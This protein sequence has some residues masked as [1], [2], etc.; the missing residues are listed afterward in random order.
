MQRSRR[1]LW[2]WTVTTVA[3]GLV[4]AALVVGVFRLAVLAAPSY[5]QDIEDWV[6]GVMNRPVDIGGMDLTWR[7]LRPTLKFSDVAL[8]GVS[9]MTPALEVAELEL[10]FTLS[11]LVRGRIMPVA[12]NVVGAVVE[13][14]R[15]IEGTVRIRGVNVSGEG[16]S[17]LVS[18][19]LAGLA[20]VRMSDASLLWHD[21]FRDRPPLWFRDVDMDIDR[22][23][24]DL[25]I[26]LSGTSHL[27][28]GRAQATMRLSRS[29][30]GT[31]LGVGGRARIEALE[32]GPWMDA[33]LPTPIGLIGD[34]LEL[35][36]QFSWARGESVVLDGQVRADRLRQVSGPGAMDH[37]R[38]EF[39]ATLDAAQQ[40]LVVRDLQMGRDG[41][42]WTADRVVV[43]RQASEARRWLAVQATHLQMESLLPWLAGVDPSGLMHRVTGD[44]SDLLA[45][46]E[47]SD[48]TADGPPELSLTARLKGA[49][50]IAEGEQPAV[51][52]LS[53]VLSLTQDRGALELDSEDVTIELPATLAHPVELDQLASSVQWQREGER[54]R[55]RLTGLS[56]AGHAARANGSVELVL[57]GEAPELDVE[58][59]LSSEDAT[60]LKSLIPRQWHPNLRAWLEQ[61]VVQGRV[62]S[63]RLRLVGAVD[64]FPFRD[65][66][67]TFRLELNINPGTLSIGKGWPTIDDAVA[68]LVI[69][70]ESL[71][72]DAVSG[73]ILGV[74]LTPAT[75]TL[76]DFRDAV[77]VAEGGANGSLDRM[78]SFLSNSPL[79][80]QVGYLD[81]VLEPRGFGHLDLA[82]EIPLKDIQA[83]RF[84][85]TVT[86]TGIELQSSQMPDVFR[87]VQGTIGFGNDGLTSTG[88]KGVFREAP[89]RVELSTV[90]HPEG[91]STQLSLQTPVRFDTTDDPW[92]RL[93]PEALRRRLDGHAS[94]HAELI[95]G[96]ELPQSLT[97]TSDLVNAVSA[98][99]APLNKPDPES[100]LPMRL[101]LPI[102]AE[103]P[104]IT[105]VELADRL[106]AQV[107]SEE[108]RWLAAAGLGFGGG[109]QPGIPDTGV[110]VT[111]T[112]PEVDVTEWAAWLGGL[113]S[114]QEGA[115]ASVTVDLTAGRLAAGP[116]RLGQQSIRGQLDGQGAEFSLA[117]AAEGTLRWE[118]AGR[119]RWEARLDHL[120]T[121][122]LAK[123]DGPDSDGEPME[124]PQRWPAIDVEIAH[125]QVA[126]LDAGRLTFKAEPRPSGI[127]LETLRLEGGELDLEMGGYAARPDD[128]TRAGLNGVLETPRI[129]KVMFAAGFVPNVRAESARIVLNLG[130]PDSPEGLHLETATGALD[131]SFRDGALAAVDPG[132]GRVLGLFSFYAL[133]RRLLLDFRDMT[134][135]GLTFDGIDGHFRISGGRAQ[136][137][138]FAVSAPSLTIDV[139]GA[140]GL[141]D[142]TYDQVITVYPDISSGVT[143]AGALFGGPAMGAILMIAQELLDRPLNQA[144]QLTYHLGGTWDDPVITRRGVETAPS[145]AEKGPRS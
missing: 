139:R 136:T 16:G 75:V 91:P 96:R 88:L 131:V 130:W 143:L 39:G 46:A 33:W 140:V 32:P 3:G 87:D 119:G 86:L 50:L 134:E 55:T 103:W 92:A 144:T 98:L 62:G 117:G 133:P 5:K 19:Q 109:G 38:A 72:V 48:S 104:R 53:G 35:S 76:D 41:A 100:K 25:D 59:A 6:A 49:G 118:A 102:H 132:A 95:L 99:P 18:E 124:V 111:G 142:R 141:T 26:D 27:G 54:W 138:D 43:E 57:G 65:G 74:A 89:V 120:Y 128:V 97:V 10:G 11:D 24:T 40:R 17:T 13:I 123:M 107:R 20:N 116:L 80:G 113:A 12:I 114:Q 93:L 68:R 66:G 110:V 7:G 105:R 29:A 42:D 77:L 47:W 8:Q 2:T 79:S 36:T 122:R 37:L 30:D 125:L 31:L 51:R 61:G 22:I 106:V 70:G 115:E 21:Q 63:G 58:L 112:A 69:D 44:V 85:G 9:P 34:P 129:D 4:L 121:E 84:D 73:R 14:V 82:L 64:E 1:R 52:G 126:D 71:S 101:E 67:G 23:G 90:Q 94:L 45:E 56:A 78:L 83:T 127:S 15:D 135:T 137:E 81:R 60:A 108:G 145:P 28:G